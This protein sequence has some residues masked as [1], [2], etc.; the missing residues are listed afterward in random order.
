MANGKSI[1]LSFFYELVHLFHNLSL[2]HDIV[3]CIRKNLIAFIALTDGLLRARTIL[4][5]LEDVGR[6]AVNFAIHELFEATHR[7][8]GI[9]CAL[10]AENWLVRLVDGPSDFP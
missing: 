7:N 6:L 1:L 3:R 5:A 2:P 8:P 9:L 10:I 4:V